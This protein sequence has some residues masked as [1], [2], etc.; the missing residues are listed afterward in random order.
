MGRVNSARRL[1]YAAAIGC[2]SADGTYVAFG[3]DKNLP[4][5][6]RWVREVNKQPTLDL[7]EAL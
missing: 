5:A 3:P 2:A 6:L 4:T 1:T 7:W